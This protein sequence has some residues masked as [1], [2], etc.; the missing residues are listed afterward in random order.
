MWILWCLGF[1]VSVVQCSAVQCNCGASA[2]ER[3]WPIRGVSYYCSCYCSSALA[4]CLGSVSVDLVIYLGN[5]A[6][7]AKYWRG[8]LRKVRG[9]GNLYLFGY[10]CSISS[11]NLVKRGNDAFTCCR[12]LEMTSVKLSLEMTVSPRMWLIG[13][14]DQ[15]QEQVCQV[16]N[17]LH[18]CCFHVADYSREKSNVY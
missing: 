3:Q 8:P 15:G 17:C 18:L 16:A 9:A 6:E 12:L 11:N 5:R 1:V 14:A 2:G 10:F 7:A 13:L 4:A